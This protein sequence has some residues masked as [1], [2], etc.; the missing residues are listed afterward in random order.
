MLR[1]LSKLYHAFFF[2]WNGL[3]YAWHSQFAFR[4]EIAICVIA[5]P[6]ALYFSHSSVELILLLNSVILILIVELINSAIETTVNRISMDH[7][8]LSGLAK[9]LGSAATLIACL[10]AVVTWGIILI[11]NAH[12]FK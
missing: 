2:S 11:N 9:D 6:L 5:I 8:K 10:N 1:I 4:L 3:K 7:H 12:V